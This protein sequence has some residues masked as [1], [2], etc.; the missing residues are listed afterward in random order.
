MSR[1]DAEELADTPAD[2]AAL[3]EQAQACDLCAATLPLGPRPI[4]RASITARLLII[5][6]APGT[7]AHLSGVPFNDP[8]GVRL[9]TWMGVDFE[10]FYDQ[11]RIGIM[12][13]GFCYPGRQPNGGDAPPAPDCAPTWHERFLPLMPNLQTILLVG[14]YAQKRYCMVTNMTEAVRVFTHGQKFL[15]LP[16]PSWRTIGWTQRNPW[17]EAEILPKLR[18]AVQRCL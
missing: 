18:A 7:K 5:S 9:R 15:A 3:I 16:H 8:S 14:G 1:A 2:L 13:M 4:F 17:F 11:T 6:Q 10:T 12:P